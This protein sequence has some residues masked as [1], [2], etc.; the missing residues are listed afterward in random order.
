MAASDKKQAASRRNGRQSRGAV[1]P[2]GRAISSQNAVSHGVLSTA[3]LLPGEQRED[4]DT[5]FCQLSQEL[6]AVGTLEQALVE[7]VAISLWRQRRLVRAESAQIQVQ[8][9]R[10]ATVAVAVPYRYRSDE[11]LIVAGIEEMHEKGQLDALD[12]EL[13]VALALLSAPRSGAQQLPL[14]CCLFG[15]CIGSAD[16]LAVADY[17][18][19]LA[20]VA[21]HGH[22]IR[23]TISRCRME[24]SLASLQTDS[25]AVP[26]A[27]DTLS[28][29]QS[30]LDN[31]LYKALRAL[32]E[33]Q[34][35][36]RR[37]LDADAS[38]IEDSG[39]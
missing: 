27:K 12:Q 23:S 3:L 32:R 39:S 36:R 30:A 9:Q 7:R 16:D 13:G 1:S 15:V 29:Y 11:A 28:R 10:A 38:R 8:Q 20:Q 26:E 6:G 14:L 34:A 5:L 2:E 19:V 25:L 37:Q 4:F 24:S 21:R 31:E 22:L 18:R 33:A 35:A 17:Q